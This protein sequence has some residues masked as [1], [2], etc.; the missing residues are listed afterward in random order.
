[1]FS[2]IVSQNIHRLRARQKLTQEA[3]AFYCGLPTSHYSQIER[4]AG[5]PTL[6]TLQ[7]M[8]TA[9]GVP[10]SRL[11]NE[12]TEENPDYTH[13]GYFI[14]DSL[15]YSWELEKL[16]DPLELLNFT[17]EILLDHVTLR[18]MD[19][20]ADRFIHCLV[21]KPITRMFR[22]EANE[23]YYS[24]GI[25]VEYINGAFH[26]QLDEISD[27]CPEQSAVTKLAA[28]MTKKKLHPEHFHD[29]TQN[30]CENDYKVQG[31]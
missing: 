27:I 3:F 31:L 11:F 16:Y 23:L 6:A 14:R 24:T 22:N 19:D 18:D 21:Y 8:A 2:K 12:G 25:R 13:L 7:K 5:N 20:A 17:S 30:F 29:V 15:P 4:S 10:L 26:H 1:M 28:L 9:F